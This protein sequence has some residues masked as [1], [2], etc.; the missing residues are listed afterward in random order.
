M[1]RTVCF[2]CHAGH[3]IG[4]GKQQRNHGPLANCSVISNIYL[5]V[6]DVSGALWLSVF[7]IGLQTKPG[8]FNCGYRVGRAGREE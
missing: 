1:L 2:E 6:M 7:R 5:A 4:T 8:K 3:D